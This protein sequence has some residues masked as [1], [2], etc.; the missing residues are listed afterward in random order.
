[1]RQPVQVVI[2]AVRRLTAGNWEYLMLK[3]C[4]P[5]ENMWQGA[6][7]GLEDGEEVIDAALRELR[8]ETGLT[9]LKIEKADYSFYFPLEDKYRHR[10]PEGIKTIL[11]VM[12]VAL[13]SADERPRLSEEHDSFKWCSKKEVL[14]LLEWPEDRAAFERCHEIVL[15][16]EKG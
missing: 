6:S 9:P 5:P 12:F 4:L 11:A 2:Y 10:Y 8:E 1:M 15:S 14:D 16:W 13:V 3:R 7:G